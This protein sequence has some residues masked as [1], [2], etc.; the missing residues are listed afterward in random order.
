M[1]S[2]SVFPMSERLRLANDSHS[3]QGICS[4]GKSPF[5]LMR[6]NCPAVI[7]PVIGQDENNAMW[8][9]LWVRGFGTLP[10][11]YPECYSAGGE[12]L[13]LPL[14]VDSSCRYPLLHHPSLWV[15]GVLYF[16]PW[17]TSGINLPAKEKPNSFGSGSLLNSSLYSERGSYRMPSAAGKRLQPSQIK[18]QPSL[19]GATESVAAQ[20]MFCEWAIC[21]LQCMMLNQELQI[22]FLSQSLCCTGQ[23]IV[24]STLKS[25]TLCKR[26]I[27]AQ[28]R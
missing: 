22:T 16:F 13:P 9:P 11:L 27:C 15:S 17:L 10:Y 7:C 4:A 8:K 24:W 6:G 20:P 12:T 14:Y 3:S 1:W 23:I 18:G 2:T 5:N 25:S 21:L 28:Q 19:A 26:A